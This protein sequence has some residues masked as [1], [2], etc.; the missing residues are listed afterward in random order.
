MPHKRTAAKQI[1]REEKARKKLEAAVAKAKAESRPVHN[2]LP[3]VVARILVAGLEGRR[4]PGIDP[5]IAEQVIAHLCDVASRTSTASAPAAG[6]TADTGATCAASP[7][8]SDPH[9]S[10]GR[11]RSAAD[12]TCAHVWQ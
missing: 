7:G 11:A 12:G 9:A 10:P 8:G 4:D 3:E 5:E 6:G 2:P 1:E